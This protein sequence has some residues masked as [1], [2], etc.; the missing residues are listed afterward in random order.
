MKKTFSFGKVDFN[1]TGRKNNL[2]TVDI[3][4]KDTK[5]G[6]EFTASGYVWNKNKT[7][8]I[9]GG[10]CLDELYKI[11]ALR[12]NDT[13]KKIYNLWKR[14]HLNGMHAGTE[15]QE[16]YIK[17]KFGDDYPGYTEVCEALKEVNL[18]ED[19]G[20]RYGTS[21]LYRPISDDDL[22]MIYQFLNN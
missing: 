15:N 11:P 14:N 20:Y 22:T 17:E 19:N 7:D 5:K 18:Y 1:G 2:V 16:N 6:P 12:S 4:L 21:W 13:F 8:F 9:R 10:Q 3:E